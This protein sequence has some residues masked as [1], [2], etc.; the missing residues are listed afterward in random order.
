MSYAVEN[1]LQRTESPSTVLIPSAELL[2]GWSERVSTPDDL[3]A[4]SES[5]AQHALDVIQRSQP[6]IVVL[7]QMFA[8][9]SRGTALVTELLSDARLAHTEIRLLSVDRSVWMGPHGPTSGAELAESGEA[10]RSPP[11]PH[12]SAGQDAYRD[13]GV[14]RWI[15]GYPR[16][17]LAG[18]GAD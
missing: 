2:A 12:G 14:R 11:T 8:F 9:T 4:F 10:L 3:L 18:G 6:D 5:D 17:P 16:G 15:T 13:R 7:E 1:L